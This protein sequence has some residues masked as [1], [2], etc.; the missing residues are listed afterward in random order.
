M[1]KVTIKTEQGKRLS[2]ITQ[3]FTQMAR[4]SPEL[5]DGANN[6]VAP[7]RVEYFN[8]WSDVQADI[9]A[10]ESR[11]FDVDAETRIIVIDEP[12]K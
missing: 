9:I 12:V 4:N 7:A 8:V 6:L 5:R 3:K 2:V 1:S 10:S 11:E